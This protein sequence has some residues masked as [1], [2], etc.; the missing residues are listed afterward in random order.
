MFQLLALAISGTVQS[1]I[2]PPMNLWFLHPVAL[3][4]GLYVLLN[5]SSGRRRFLCGWF[6]GI[7]SLVTIFYWLTHTVRNFAMM[8]WPLAI[9]VLLLFATTY[10]LY[11]GLFA[12]GSAHVRRASGAF[13]PVG[14]A[15]WFVACEFLNP[16]LFPFYQGVAWYQ[17]PRFFLV[18]SVTGVEG[19]SFQVVLWNLLVVAMVERWRAGAR[20]M[21]LDIARGWAVA[22][23]ALLFSVGV[24]LV[25]LHRIRD[26]E[27]TAEHIRLGLVQANLSVFDRRDLVRSDPYGIANA[28]L[29]LMQDALREHGRVDAF[30]WPEG[31]IRGL[32]QSKYNKQLLAFADEA[33]VEI[34]TGGASATGVK[35]KGFQQF[36]SA[37]RVR[38]DGTLDP[39]KYDKNILLPFGE[40][41]PLKDV[42][43]IL[44]EIPG[45]GNFTPGE[46]LVVYEHPKAK[47][48]FLICYEAIRHEYVRTGV[49]AGAEL[50]VNI[51]YDAWFGDTSCPS[52]HLMLSAIQAAEYGRPLV[53]AATTGIS[54]VTDARGVLLQ[55][56]EVFTEDVLVADVPLVHVSTIYGRVGDV[57][58]WTCIF[59]GFGLLG[60]GLSRRRDDA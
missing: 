38:D 30:I 55:Q 35:G 24:S 56:T 10:S 4:P 23:V 27:A 12:W 3:V 48:C 37:F 9:A 1:V 6:M 57:F 31:A 22:A 15:A 41:M 32:P 50:L 51:T 42:F 2:S 19:V 60:L 59:A 26:A 44:G 21:S 16:Q 34:W 36:N 54:A 5:E 28:H 33:D 17:L 25:Q 39:Q 45:V 18:T 49:Q 13:W 40:F 58:A 14:V 29:E 53:R 7:S 43:P 47:F 46:G 20:P 52:Q 8:P 11:M